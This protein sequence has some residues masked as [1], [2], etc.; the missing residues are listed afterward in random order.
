MLFII[1]MPGAGKTYWGAQIATATGQKFIDLDAWIEE[2]EGLTIR[3]LFDTRG[4]DVFRQKEHQY[5]ARLIDSV[6]A[7]TVIACGGGTP[8][9]HQNIGMMRQAGKVIYLHSE[10]NCLIENINKEP[11][12]RPLLIG[13]EHLREYLTA[14]L[15][16]RKTFYEQAHYILPAENLTL[17]NFTQIIQ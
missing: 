15:S 14:L 12:K 3:Q 1:G 9:F 13:M 7:N 16:Q 4:E 10:I 8:C 5:L 17:S 6:P 2:K 11:D